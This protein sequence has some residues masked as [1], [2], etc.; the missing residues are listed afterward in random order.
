MKD[1]NVQTLSLL[2]T[3]MN[4]RTRDVRCLPPFTVCPKGVMS[5]PDSGGDICEVPKV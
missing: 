1:V 5:P 4:P 3:E 2:A